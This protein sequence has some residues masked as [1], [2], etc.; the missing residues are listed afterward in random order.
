MW[1]WADA[2]DRARN[3]VAQM[4]N[5]EKNNITFGIDSP[6]D[7]CSGRSG[8]VPRLGFPGLCLQ[9]AGNGVRG[10]DMV[11]AYASGIHVGASWNRELAFDRAKFMGAEFRRKGANLALGPTS[12]PLGKIARGGR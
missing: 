11:N 2:Y 10:T 9:D 6:L 4:T 8:S 1:E 5:A 7:G 3:L 12:G